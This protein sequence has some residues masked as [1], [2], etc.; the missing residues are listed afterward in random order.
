LPEAPIV[1]KYRGAQRVDADEQFSQALSDS[2]LDSLAHAGV[3]L[4]WINFFNGF[5]I[6][7]EKAELERLRDYM[8]RAHSRGLKVAASIQVGALVPETLQLEENEAQ[9]W[10]QVNSNG[11]HP[12]ISS[13]GGLSLSRPCFNSESFL[14]F[15]ERVCSL[16]GRLSRGDRARGG[17]ALRTDAA[18]AV[19]SRNA[20]TSIATSH[21]MRTLRRTAAPNK[22]APNLAKW[23]RVVVQE[24]RARVCVR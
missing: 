24:V 11:Q 17:V 9:N 20:I 2:A 18:R 10:L 13:H 1:Q 19:P 23:C 8:S 22:R 4:V 15:M 21:H 12:L 16:A 6:E 14:R 3:T 5:G 7:F